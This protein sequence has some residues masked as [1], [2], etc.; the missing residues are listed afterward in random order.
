[1]GPTGTRKVLF[2]T[3]RPLAPPTPL[4]HGMCDVAYCSVLLRCTAR[5]SVLQETKAARIKVYR[6]IFLIASG[7]YVFLSSLSSGTSLL[8]TFERVLPSNLTKTASPPAPR[9]RR[10]Q[11]T[12]Q[13][14]SVPTCRRRVGGARRLTS[15][16]CDA[17]STDLCCTNPKSHLYY[18]AYCAAMLLTA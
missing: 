18:S 17:R 9:F 6:P 11:N 10:A 13:R 14:H 15:P 16:K 7:L 2:L 12:L 3:L 8:I 5:N 4:R 1:M